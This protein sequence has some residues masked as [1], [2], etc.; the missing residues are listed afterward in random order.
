MAVP[1]LA[2]VSLGQAGDVHQAKQHGGVAVGTPVPGD[3]TQQFFPVQGHHLA[4]EELVGH[5]DRRPV[6]QGIGGLLPQKQADHPIGDVPQ[7][8][9][10]GRHVGVVQGG[11]GGRI[12]GP[13]HLNGVFRGGV[14]GL[15][16]GQNA[17]HKGGVLQQHGVDGKD[18]CRLRTHHQRGLVVQIG[19]LEHRPALGGL[20]PEDLIP[21]GEV[22]EEVQLERLAV[23]NPKGTVGNLIQNGFAGQDFHTITAP[24]R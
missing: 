16:D 13:C 5:Q 12:T 11:K 19:Q 15:D 9:P 6:P 10:A 24:L 2:D 22:G 14:L 20:E 18:G 3:Q 8:G 17:V 4:G 1:L 23:V 7:V 21:R